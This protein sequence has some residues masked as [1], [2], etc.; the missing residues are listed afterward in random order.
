[1]EALVAEGYAIFGGDVVAIRDGIL[2]QAIPLKEGGI[3]GIWPWE[4]RRRSD[5]AW[6]DFC[7]RSLTESLAVINREKPEEEVKE[8]FK[9][10]I[11]FD[12]E[13][14]RLEDG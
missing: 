13:Y 7:K 5:E 10:Y 11:Y 14:D 2:L 8:E 3:D 12:L 6:S 9:D 4:I 1:M